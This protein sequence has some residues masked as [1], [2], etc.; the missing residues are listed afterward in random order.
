LFGDLGTLLS[1]DAN[2]ANKAFVLLPNGE[3]RLVEI[4]PC[5]LLN[6]FH[7]GEIFI[8]VFFALKLT[9]NKKRPI[10]DS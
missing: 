7:E 8:N 1:D 10:K 4:G 9:Q 2:A 3:G 5:I 6:L